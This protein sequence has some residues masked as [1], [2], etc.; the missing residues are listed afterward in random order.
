MPDNNVR[1]RLR[2]YTTLIELHRSLR[3]LDAAAAESVVVV[4]D[5]CFCGHLPSLIVRPVGRPGG[6]LVLVVRSG[7]ITPSDLVSIQRGCGWQDIALERRL[8]AAFR[9]AP[10]PAGGQRSSTVAFVPGWVDWAA[11]LDV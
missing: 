8:D 1:I 10:A 5:A 9:Q 4:L 3:D 11:P 2:P 7:R 6:R